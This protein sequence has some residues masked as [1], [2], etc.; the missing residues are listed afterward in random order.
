MGSVFYV[1]K[2]WRFFLV[3]AIYA[4]FYFIGSANPIQENNYNYANRAIASDPLFRSTY[5][6]LKN[7]LNKSELDDFLK[8]YTYVLIKPDG[9]A[10]GNFQKIIQVLQDEGFLV[11]MIKKVK[12]DKYQSKLM[13]FYDSFNFPDEFL[14]ISS[15]LMK[16]KYSLVVIILDTNINKLE[17]KTAAEHFTSIK[18]SSVKS[19]RSVY[20]I[21]ERIGGSDG[22]L[23][24]IHSPNS[25]FDIVR[26]LG[27]LLDNQLSECIKNSINQTDEISQE[28]LDKIL[29]LIKD[30]QIKFEYHDLEYDKVILRWEKAIN[31]FSAIKKQKFW[32][33]INKKDFVMAD[34]LE[35]NEK[36]DLHISPWD[37]TVFS[38]YKLQKLF[39]KQKNSKVN[40]NLN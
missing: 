7:K 3:I 6:E 21:R 30:E 4:K 16:D 15:Y 34:L 23:C 5:N 17:C 9:L 36:Y 20:D 13:W 11:K 27:I 38:A 18:G 40:M 19:K 14:E 1:N 31:K 39:E 25:P 2:I 12:F 28:E 35:I 32:N 26:E 37:I 24:F 10:S 22:L 29:E 33:I 8:N